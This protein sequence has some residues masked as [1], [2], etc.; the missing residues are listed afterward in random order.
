MMS[1]NNL[2]RL[3]HSKGFARF[4][5]NVGQPLAFEAQLL[6]LLP[7]AVAGERVFKKVQSKWT[8]V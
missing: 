7:A 6:L 5:L 3:N 2:I 8:Y 1:L 4:L